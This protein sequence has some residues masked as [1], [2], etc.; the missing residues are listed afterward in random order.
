MI[1]DPFLAGHGSNSK[2]HRAHDPV[3]HA[4]SQCEGTSLNQ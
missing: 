1:P 3:P 2:L 4:A